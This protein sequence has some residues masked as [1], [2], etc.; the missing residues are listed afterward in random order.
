MRDD[1]LD[2]ELQF[3]LDERIA[4]L[5]GK[6]MTEDEARR[7]A[8]LELGGVMQVKEA[9]RDHSLRWLIAEL[10]QDGTY[11][12]RT[13][14]RQPG[15]ALVSIL[16]LTLG[17]GANTA[18]FS[19][20]NAVVLRPLK[21]PNADTLVRFITTTGVSTSI[22]G[23]QSFDMWR[24]QSKVFENVSA[25]RLEYVNLTEGAEPEQVPVARVS[26]EFFRLFRA[27]VLN[28]RTFDASEDRPGGPL[29]AVLSHALWA[30]RFQSDPA[31]LGR[32]LSL[33]NVPYVIVGILDSGFDTEQFDAQPDVWVPFQLDL[34]RID[35]GNLF[36]VTGRLTPGTT[37]AA[38][39][40]QLAVAVAA[41]RRDAPGRLSARTVWTV[42]PLRDAMI[43]SIRPSLNLLVVAVGLLLLIACAN[44]SNLLL[45][46]ADV[47][48]REIAIRAALGAARSR[49]FRQLLTESLILSLVGGALGLVTGTIGVRILLATYPGN[50]PFRLGDTT[51]AIPRI[52]ANAAVGIDW[53]VFAFALAASVVTGVILGVLPALYA[54]RVDLVGPMKRAGG[55]PGRRTKARAMLVVTE[56][57]LAVM[58][59]VGAALLIRTSLALRAVDA[60]FDAHNVV[61]MRTSITA[62]R[63]ETRAGI[64]QLTRDAVNEIRAVPGVLSATATCCMPLETVWQLPFVVSG[65]PPE[66]LTR[67]GNLAY[68]GFA[69]WTFVAPNYFEVLK[70]PIVRGRGITDSD[71]AD[72]RSVV[73]I[74]E[75]MA[76]RFF[77]TSDPLNNQLIVGKG[78]RPEYDQEPPRQIVGIVGNI[79]DTGLTRPARPAMYVPVAQEPDGVT[80]LNVRLLP[81]VWMARTATRPLAAAP[82]IEK[83]LQRAS[84]LPV[85]RIRSMEEIVA[86]STARSRFDMWLMSIFGGSALLLAAIGVYGLITYS[87]QQRT[88]EIG[89]R[90][91]LGASKNSVGMMVL[92]HGMTLAGLGIIIGIAAAFALA[93]VLAGFLF[94]VAPRDPAVFV[95]VPAILAV[96]AF[97]AVWFP[98]RRAT[99]LDPIAALRQE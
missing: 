68:T 71:T 42:E 46:R 18:I 66:T 2:K 57:A 28:G 12:M 6:G 85:T 33:G 86:E 78:M 67:A 75:E 73:V 16:T 17:I 4:D 47:R 39:N 63:F 69:G 76:R 70:I 61:T 1:E 97:A 89:I 49:I 24:Q 41:A 62:T 60:G 83:A 10:W 84:G 93:R 74:N 45:V 13:F 88:V 36:T 3:H 65:R 37:R 8:R 35:G 38:A 91:A 80:A 30:R 90:M 98:A 72:G 96:V 29:V 31:V 48:A 7:R 55:S 5:M 22:A 79:R 95:S 43:G 64:A 53:R 82:S 32:R 87:V 9:I 77:P 59:V 52:G 20:V 25:H 58:L 44:V 19:V 34:H 27:S 92:R 11:A 99:R 14:W 50:N 81:I 21:T 94:G 51:A 15:F 23:A 54:S 40:A 56:V 26:A